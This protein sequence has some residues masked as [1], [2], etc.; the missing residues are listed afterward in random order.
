MAKRENVEVQAHLVPRGK[1]VSWVTQVLLG[2]Q[3]PW[4]QLDY[5]VL[6]EQEARP[7]A[8]VLKDKEDPEDQMA[9]QGIK[10]DMVP[11]VKKE[12]KGKEGFLVVPVRL[13]ALGRGEFK[14]NQAYKDSP[15]AQETWGLPENQGREDCLVMLDFLERWVWRDLRALRATLACKVNQVL[16]EMLDLP[17][18]REPLGSQGRE[19]NQELLEK[20]VSK[21]KMD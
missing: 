8:Q 17:A 14:E 12:T 3:D 18:A 1:K 2:L 6:L 15:A 13:E 9:S 10:V 16:R 21:E 4:A 20:K 7:G 11:R 5:L 19:E